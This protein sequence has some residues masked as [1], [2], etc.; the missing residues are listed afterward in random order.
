[1][2]ATA[3]HDHKRGE[4]V[5]ARLA[6]LSELAAWTG[7]SGMARW[8][9]QRRAA[10]H[11]RRCPSAG[12]IAMLLQTIVGAWPLDLEPT[13]AVGRAA[14]AE[15]LGWQQ[16]ALREAKLYSDWAV[17]ER[18]LTRRAARDLLVV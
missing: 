9:A 5:R 8:V 10:V 7:P 18:E 12:D 16:K 4:D 11:R 17:A 15:R 1:M 2:L 14:F 3:T 6:V 13:T